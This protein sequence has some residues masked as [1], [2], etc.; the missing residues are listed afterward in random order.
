MKWYKNGVE[1]LGY[2]CHSLDF[3]AATEEDEGDYYAVLTNLAGTITTNV[4]AFRLGTAC[5]ASGA[6]A[7]DHD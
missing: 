6:R 3:A 4:V 1:L 5:S 7:H 2:N